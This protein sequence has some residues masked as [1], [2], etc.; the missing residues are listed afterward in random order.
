MQLS[1]KW[2]AFSE[3]FVAF[4]KFTLNFDHLQKK[5]DLYNWLIS[6]ITHSEKRV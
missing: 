4:S 2:K 5:D 1:E 3:F 6:E